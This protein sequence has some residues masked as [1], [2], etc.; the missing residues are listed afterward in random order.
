MTPMDQILALQEQLIAAQMI[1][2]HIA[3]PHCTWMGDQAGAI[4]DLPLAEVVIPGTHDSGSYGITPTSPASPDADPAIKAAA[5]IHLAIASDWAKAQP[6]P[7][8]TQ[9]LRGIRYFDMRVAFA[10]EPD[11]YM[12]HSLIGAKLS[13]A[14][15]DI[16]Q[17]LS[18]SWSQ[19]EVVILDFQHIFANAPAGQGASYGSLASLIVKLI[20][21]RL[22]PAS[23]TPRSTLNELWAANRQVI[24]IIDDSYSGI[25]SDFRDVP[26]WFRSNT[27]SSP[28]QKTFDLGQLLTNMLS[29]LKANDRS[30]LFVLQGILNPPDWYVGVQAANIFT[31]PLAWLFKLT[32]A[33]LSSLED[34]GN[35]VTPQVDSW[36]E[37]WADQGLGSNIVI[38]DWFTADPDY[39]GRLTRLNLRNR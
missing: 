26:V 8:R 36:I 35:L 25:T 31:G 38:V 3:F 15:T 19:K 2:L 22:T 4:G 6:A 14:L 9:L 20:G 28:Y 32:H 23:F 34:L 13:E 33:T 30:K 39:A 12:T 21:K 17:F 37:Q 29:N 24:V 1:G 11:W 16:D 18:Q 7:F 27:L 10:N 5:A